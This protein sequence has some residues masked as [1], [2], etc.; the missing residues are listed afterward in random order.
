MVVSTLRIRPSRSF[1]CS[2]GTLPAASQRS[3]RSRK[4]FLAASTSVTGSSASAS[5]MSFSLTSALAA[6]SASWAARGSVTGT[7]E[8]VLGAAEPLPQLLVDVLGRR[9]GGLPLAHQ[10]AVAAGGRAELGGGGQ[11][12]GLLDQA[13]LDQRGRLRASR[14]ARRSAPCGV[15]CTP[16]GRSRTASRARRRRPG[17]CGAAPSSGRGSRGG[18]WRRD[19]SRC[20][21]R[22]SRPRRPASPSPSFD[23]AGLLRLLGLADRALL[24]DHRPERVEARHQRGQVADGVGVDELGAHGLDRLGRLLGAEHRRSAPAGPGG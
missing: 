19:A 8:R 2:R 10:V 6:N 23:S 16:C 3:A 20:R 15:A 12:L 1:I 7:E 17:R 13:Q 14:P 18:G 9:A 21:R 5:T 24:G 4:A 22:S 11:R